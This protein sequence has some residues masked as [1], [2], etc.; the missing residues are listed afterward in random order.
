MTNN[1]TPI[2]SASGEE[3]IAK[4]PKVV[5][6][7]PFGSKILVEILDPSETVETNLHIPQNVS[8]DG[9]PQAYIVELGPSVDESLGL[10]E[11]QRVYWT[12]KG[13]LV[14]D[15]RATRDR[16]LLEIHNILAIIE[17]EGSCCGGNCEA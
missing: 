6:V 15:P 9:A 1:H 16:A 11:G 3:L 7:K 8:N 12:G 14:E 5:A 17:E 2:F 13:T 10:K 4:P